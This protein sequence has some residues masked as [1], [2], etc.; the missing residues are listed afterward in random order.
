MTPQQTAKMIEEERLRADKELEV[1]LGLHPTRVL[2]RIN[3][4]LFVDAIADGRTQR[5]AAI[6]AGSRSRDPAKAAFQKLSKQPYLREQ[7]A[8]AIHEKK[9]MLLQGITEQKRDGA[10]LKENTSAMRDLQSIEDSVMG[11]HNEKIVPNIIIVNYELGHNDSAPIRSEPKGVAVESTA[12][13]V[14]VQDPGDAAEKRKDRSRN[15]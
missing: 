11:V 7:V 10:G 15:K 4:E 5:D 3:D 9:M 13:V 8:Q 2:G 1:E 12:R 14:S 6:I